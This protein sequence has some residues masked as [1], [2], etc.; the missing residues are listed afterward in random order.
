M[1]CVIG[2]LLLYSGWHL[3]RLA[4]RGGLRFAA[5]KG[6]AFFISRIR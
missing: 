1:I 2:F 6:K 3:I 5:L 4:A